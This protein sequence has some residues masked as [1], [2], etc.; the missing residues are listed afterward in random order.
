MNYRTSCFWQCGLDSADSRVGKLTG[1]I[2]EGHEPSA[3]KK[4][5]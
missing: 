1:C 3:F 5:K 4:G 2:E